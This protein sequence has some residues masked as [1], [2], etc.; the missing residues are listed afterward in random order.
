MQS[1]FRKAHKNNKEQL[2]QYFEFIKAEV[3]NGGYFKDALDWYMLR[4]VNPMVDRAI[5]VVVSLIA[6]ISL[7]FLSQIIS[8]AFPLV[9][10]VPVV[11]RDYDMSLYRPVIKKLKKDQ[12]LTI[13]TSDEAVAKY[14]L[15]SYISDREAYDFRKGEVK[16]VNQK[17]NRVKNNSSFAEYKNFQLFMSRDN[18]D[19]PINNFGRNIYKDIEITSF[20][21]VREAPKNRYQKLKSLFSNRIPTQA[22]VKF[23]AKTY[24]KDK[25]GKYQSESQDYLAKIK[26][27]FSGLDRN[28]KSGVLNFVVNEYKLYRVQ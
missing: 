25:E 9:E 20:E 28:A 4:Y 2:D 1:D 12:D 19:S 10:E 6:A 23:R 21:F 5:M 16:S 15:T 26:F 17:F 18:A 7:Y 11:I 8:N 13:K 14:L 3:E 27:N 24:F 22:N